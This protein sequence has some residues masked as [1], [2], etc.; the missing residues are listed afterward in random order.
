MSVNATFRLHTGQETKREPLLG[1]CAAAGGAGR[2]RDASDQ[3]V[4][5]GANSRLRAV[6][7]SRNDTNAQRGVRPWPAAAANYLELCTMEVSS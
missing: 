1:D 2:F 4:C 3:G 6:Q 5:I 7:G